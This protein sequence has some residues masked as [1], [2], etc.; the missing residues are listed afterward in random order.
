MIDLNNLHL[1]QNEKIRDP[2]SC[3]Q[4]KKSASGIT[5]INSI[6][7]LRIMKGG[8]LVNRLTIRVQ[9]WCKDCRNESKR[10]LSL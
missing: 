9:S 8:P 7:G 1:N 5:S 3:P 4:C 2:T 6:F 10:C